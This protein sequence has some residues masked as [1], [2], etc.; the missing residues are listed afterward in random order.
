MRQWQ[1]Y[2]TGT[3]NL[4]TPFPVVAKSPKEAK[5]IVISLASLNPAIIGRL[6]AK[7]YN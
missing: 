3:S 5:L 4:V 2:F 6:T 1:V 7:Q